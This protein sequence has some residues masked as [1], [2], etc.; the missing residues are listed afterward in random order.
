MSKNTIKKQI[1]KKINN[2]MINNA[3]NKNFL[4]QNKIF[5]SNNLYKIKDEDDYDYMSKCSNELLDENI[6]FINKIPCFTVKNENPKKEITNRLTFCNSLKTKISF[7]DCK[8]SQNN[9]DDNDDIKFNTNKDKKNKVKLI[10]KNL[11]KSYM[12]K[13]YFRAH[14]PNI[15]RNKKNIF[16]SYNEEIHTYNNIN[17]YKLINHEIFFINKKK[18]ISK[19]NKKNG[20]QIISPK[21]LSKVNNYLYYTLDNK[22]NRKSPIEKKRKEVEVKK[23]RKNRLLKL[24]N[25]KINVATMKIEILNNYKKNKSL[26][27][28]KKKI[29]YNRIYCKNDLKNLKENYYNN[30]QKHL[31][32]IKYL[33]MRISK[34]EEKFLNI[35]EHKE[36]IK[37]EEL[38]FKLQKVDLIEKIIILQKA[39]HDILNRDS[40]TND[41]NHFDESF[42]EQT[43]KDFS[44][45]EYSIAKD[46]IGN[47]YNVY[48]MYNKF[49][50]NKAYFTEEILYDKRINTKRNN[51]DNKK[52]IKFIKTF[53][54]KKNK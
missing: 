32:Q 41:T 2:E 52:E 54:E 40:T 33:K 8:I 22:L 17:N 45:T 47:N 7:I 49:K 16:K 5:N 20:N 38:D 44:F 25:Q 24:L 31:E 15:E 3:L 6:Q 19:I 36:I 26:S 27:F 23:D 53:R 11:K 29:E 43:I 37:N 4:Y 21:N 50:I 14:S 48:N 12:N 13:R 39:L 35:N 9:D 42:E 34:C 10:N 46:K 28:I 18:L 1:R 30:I 51:E